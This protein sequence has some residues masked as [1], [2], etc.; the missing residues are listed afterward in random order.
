MCACTIYLTLL[1]RLECSALGDII[2]HNVT[3]HR[4]VKFCP[5]AGLCRRFWGT[6]GDLW[7]TSLGPLRT[8]A[9]CLQEL[10]WTSSLALPRSPQRSRRGPPESA[11]RPR[12]GRA[13]VAH[14]SHRGRAKVAHSCVQQC[15]TL[16]NNMVRRGVC[17]KGCA[18][19][20][21]CRSLYL[22]NV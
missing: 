11:Q 20:L 14:R 7:G 4:G 8:S 21:T 18:I 6:L 22:G 19:I 17:T 12:R 3:Q 9:G 13:K 1:Y 15:A 10:W 5:R 16:C 2:Q